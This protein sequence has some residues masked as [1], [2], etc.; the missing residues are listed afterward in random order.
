MTNRTG[1][2]SIAELHEMYDHFCCHCDETAM[3]DQFLVAERAEGLYIWFKGEGEPYLDLVMGYSSLNFGHQYPRI[4]KAV[5]EGINKIDHLHS[6][7]CES[8]ILLSKLLVEKT[9]GDNNKNVY[10]PVG[11][12]MAV[13]NAVKLARAYT[14]KS[15]IISFSGGFHGYSYNAMMLTD[16]KLINKEQY[17]LCPAEEVRLP[18]ADCYRC[19]YEADCHLQCLKAV[20]EYSSR[21]K[22]IAAL[23]IEPVQGAAGFIIPR[24]EFIAGLKRLCEEYKILLI[25]DEIQ[26]GLG[27]TGK[28]FAIEHFNVEPDMILL[29]KS[30]AGGYYPLGAIITRAEIMNHISPV[31]S[32]IGA[33]FGDS[34]LGTYIA[35]EVM[36]AFEEEK[37]ADNAERV[38][39]YFTS[40]LKQFE[41]YENIDN[42]TG[43]GLAQS[44]EVVKSKKTRAPAP[45]IA[46]RLQSEALKRHVIIYV[47]GVNKN[48]I[49][50]ILPLWVGVRDIDMIIKKL[51]DILE[52]TL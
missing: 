32:A 25:D 18:Y 17:D 45:E 34:P 33:T 31:G 8:K 14:K 29:C 44:F 52:A 51:R 15:K 39:N 42:V 6:F 48:R 26:V 12:A 27:R 7:N 37:L 5:T 40:E 1:E 2:Y 10:F 47:A 4:K 19:Q 3:Y 24:K 22:D 38:G 46:Q 23:I 16:K 28:M 30:L 50:F 49:K 41:Q 43:I 11:G 9:P 21:E 35:L 36:R 13:D 20:E